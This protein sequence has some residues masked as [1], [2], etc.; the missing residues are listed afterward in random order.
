MN[1]PTRCQMCHNDA[2]IHPTR[3]IREEGDATGIPKHVSLCWE[4]FNKIGRAWHTDPG[5]DFRK[6]MPPDH[7]WKSREE[8]LESYKER[9]MK[10]L[11]K[12][13]SAMMKRDFDY[14]PDKPS[15][16]DPQ[17]ND[18]DCG[19]DKPHWPGHPVHCRKY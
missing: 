4:C 11:S 18:C 19:S 14:P 15:P 8:E 3:R 2:M 5:P 17:P 12:D 13:F 7:P 10:V 1:E 16:G 9:Y 6:H